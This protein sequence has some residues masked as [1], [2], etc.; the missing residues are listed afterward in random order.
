MN[1]VLEKLE[2][3]FVELEKI[4]NQWAIKEAAQY[5]MI[6]TLLAEKLD[7][8]ED[9]KNLYNPVVRF[10]VKESEDWVSRPGVGGG[11]IKAGLK[12]PSKIS[13]SKRKI[14]VDAKLKEAMMAEVEARAALK[15]KNIL[16]ETESQ[17][18]VME[19][20]FDDVE[21]DNEI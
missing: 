17:K 6:M 14:E 13:R 11:V 9:Q 2:I 1:K 12:T 3:V 5:P 18:S 20:V 19:D 4:L 8:D 21:E 16:S 10:Y 15:S 7:W